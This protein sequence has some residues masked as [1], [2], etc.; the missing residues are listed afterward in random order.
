MK[1][2]SVKPTPTSG[3]QPSLKQHSTPHL[4]TCNTHILR[5]IAMLCIVTPVVGYAQQ[6]TDLGAVSAADG[7]GSAT[8]TSRIPA[9]AKSAPSQGSLE[10]RSAQSEVSEAFIRNY[11]SPIA[12]FSQVIQMTPGVYS[13]SPNGPG[14][15]DTKTY[16]RGF[17]DGDYSVTFDGIPFQDTNSPTHHTW[18]FFPA[19]F[20]GGAVVDR[21]PGSA[22]TIGP[23]NFGGSINLLSRNLDPQQRTSVTGSYGTW[24][25]SLIGL[26]HETGQFGSDGSSNLLFNV[27]EMKS[28]G[29]ETYNKQKRD[30]IS[31]KYQFAITD[32]TALTVFASSI[33]LHTNT[34]NTKGPTRAQVAQYGDNY[35]MS[36]D[37][38]QANYY[39]YNFYHV[40][41]DFEYLGLTSNLGNG[42]K[43]D[44]KLYTYAYHNQQ[45]YNGTTIT[46][47]SGTDKLNAY[48]TYGNL[49]RLSQESGM[50][51]LRTGLWSEYADTNRY[52]IP[53][54]PRTWIDAVLPNFHE[55]FK[56][57][58]LQ[59]F[60]EYEFNVTND[61]K[62]TPGVKYASYRQDFTQFADNG[63]TVGSLGGAPSISHATTYNSTLPSLDVHYKLQQNW[64]AYAQFA[65]GSEIPPTNVFDV[66]N[67]N[68]TVLPAM[69]KTKTFQIGTVWKSERFTLDVDAYHIKF[70]NA[71]SSSTDTSGNTTF[72]ANGTSVTQGVEAESNIILGGGFSLYI[73]G[74]YGSSKYSNGQWVASAPSD[75]ETLGLS[76]EQGAWNTGWFTKRVG[77]M[78]N[79][80]GGIHQAVSIDP[81]LLSNLFVNYTWKNPV[82]WAK[83]AKV[84]FG[85]NNLFDNHSI[86]G[87]T[88]A[89]TKTSVPAPGDQLT[90]LPARSTSLTLTLDF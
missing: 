33:D 9:A 15:G 51:T 57:T 68:V 40:T 13:Y 27:H 44:D 1:V 83:Q 70:D 16:F 38:K 4:K 39:G 8:Q 61:L 58:T 77:K 49:L 25:T 84:Q 19:Q 59:P 17:Q 20:I 46:T 75:T 89:S 26:E 42:W 71:Y 62:I 48:R 69:V 73:N 79:D 22:A 87:V 29:Y 11:T 60:V 63:K 14:L 6:A 12:D 54:D 3:V 55:K 56:T 37:P 28:D 82:S 2:R 64:S 41:S 32:N 74:T 86:V 23:A 80:N 88:P 81:F 7:S 45:N 35:L 43:L 47:T 24:N 67:A 34:P 52:Q 36:G 5:A 10:A 85:V 65:T 90:L 50:G 18:A 72:Y 66:K 78:Y 31:L 21:S 30:A 53:S 76:Y